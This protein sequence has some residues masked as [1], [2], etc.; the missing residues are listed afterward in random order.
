MQIIVKDLLTLLEA[1]GAEEDA[2]INID[3]SNYNRDHLYLTSNEV[4]IFYNGGTATK[5]VKTEEP[6]KL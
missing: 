5:T 2:F 6:V 3:T 4:S 1:L